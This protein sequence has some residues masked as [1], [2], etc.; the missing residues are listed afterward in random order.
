MSEENCYCLKL[1]E[2]QIIG[3]Q[4][5]Q[6]LYCQTNMYRNCTVKPIYIK[7]YTNMYKFIQKLNCQT[8]MYRNCIVKPICT[9]IVLSNKLCQEILLCSVNL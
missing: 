2:I 1:R 6:K 9:E 8:N 5:V 3:N 4:Y 7:L